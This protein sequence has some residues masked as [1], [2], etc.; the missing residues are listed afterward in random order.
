MDASNLRA[1]SVKQWRALALSGQAVPVRIR[2]NGSSMHPLI[3]G[4]RDYVT[5]VPI[6][7][8]PRA[9]DIVLFP[10]KRLG[11]DYVLHRVW[12][13]EGQYMLTLGDGCLHPDAWMDIHDAWGRVMRIERGRL[14]ID[15]DRPLWRATA[16]LWMSLYPIRR[17]LFLPR[18]AYCIVKRIGIKKVK[19]NQL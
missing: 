10:G 14:V 5:I 4:W 17:W 7:R 3:R 12:K 13:V 19:K 18:R 1:L 2:V 8:P 6:D 15:P 9:G 11:V 16:L